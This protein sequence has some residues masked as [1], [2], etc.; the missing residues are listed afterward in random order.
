MESGGDAGEFP[1]P[2]R[3]GRRDAVDRIVFGIAVDSLAGLGRARRRTSQTRRRPTLQTARRDRAHEAIREN[4]LRV[5]Q[6]VDDYP[7]QG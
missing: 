6:A 3:L 7:K 4:G 2:P 5:D 1:G